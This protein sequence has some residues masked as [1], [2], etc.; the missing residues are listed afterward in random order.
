MSA[1]DRDALRALVRETLRDAL[2]GIA[3]D[4]RDGDADV[5]WVELRGDDDLARLV[6]DV[7]RIADDP[8]DGPRLRDGRLRFRLRTPSAPATPVQPERPE[9]RIERGAVTE[10]HVRA[11]EAS[12]TR[13][14]LGPA[15]VLTPMARDRARTAGV[16][17][18]R[19]R[20]GQ[21]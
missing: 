18:V 17:I 13:L 5:R 15:A 1:L 21:S 19:E 20:K 9:Q 10:R 8:Q 12:G 6:A 11:A 4:L 2:P 14:V 16:E 7:V 3:A